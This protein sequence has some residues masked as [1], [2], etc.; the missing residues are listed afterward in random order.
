MLD[1]RIGA[2]WTMCIGLL[3]SAAGMVLLMSV[4]SVPMAIVF[5]GVYGVA[6][7]LMITSGQIVFAD[8]FGREALGAIR[9]SAAPLQMG[10]NAIGPLVGGA[11]YDLTGSYLAAFIPFTCAYLLAATAL[12]LARRPARPV[13]AFHAPGSAAAG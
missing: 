9:G 4:H 1:I 10:L 8:Y 13:V 2:R 7:G 3:G 5:A 11:A 12:A 6:F